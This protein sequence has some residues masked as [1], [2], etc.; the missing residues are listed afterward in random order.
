LISLLAVSMPYLAAQQYCINATVAS[1]PAAG[2][3]LKAGDTANI[4]LTQTSEIQPPLLLNDG[5]DPGRNESYTCPGIEKS[6]SHAT[7]LRMLFIGVH[8]RPPSPAR[9]ILCRPVS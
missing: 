8:R 5:T 4:T 1:T 3:T 2:T 6:P 7:L 9:E